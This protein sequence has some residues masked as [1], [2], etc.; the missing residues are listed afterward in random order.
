MLKLVDIK[1]TFNQDLAPEDLKIALKDINLHIKEGEFVTII[2]SN[3]SG[4]STLFNIVN[5]SL[6]PDYGSVLIAGKDVTKLKDHQRA[7]HIGIVFQDPLSGTAANMTILE[8]L[9]LANMKQRRKR[10]RWAFNRDLNDLFVK[11]LE[12]LNLGLETRINQKIG[13]LSGGQRQAVTLLMAIIKMPKVLLLDEHT[14]A[15]D[16]KTAQV[17]LKLTDSIVKENNLTTIMITHNLKEALEYG[18]RLIMLAE[19]EIVLDLKNEEKQSMT[20]EKLVKVFY[21]KNIIDSNIT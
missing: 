12:K 16:P 1:K 7:K 17:V 19:G 8:N 2:G 6:Q 14:A 20:L 5:G 10:L 3:G 21:E 9:L 11:E 18:N 13:V 15:L 4:K